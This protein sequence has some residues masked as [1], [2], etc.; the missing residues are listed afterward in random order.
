MA[1]RQLGTIEN[2]R[3]AEQAAHMHDTIGQGICPFC[4]IDREINKL[5][6][7][8]YHWN[9]WP[10]P[11]PYARRKHHFV[12]ATKEHIVDV[13]QLTRAMWAEIGD[14]VRWAAEA[15]NIEGGAIIMRFGDPMYTASTI[16]HLHAHIDA[17]DGVGPAIAV[18]S[19]IDSAGDVPAQ[20][21]EVLAA[22][23]RK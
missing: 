22:V 11:F 12:L 6:K 10:N 4:S 21:A 20:Q 3:T 18:F 14:V 19:K 7:A 1:D 2:A 15:F 13:R 16:A 8:T 9:L 5:I 23:M 17:P